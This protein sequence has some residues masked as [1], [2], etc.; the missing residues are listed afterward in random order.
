[1][2]G[3]REMGKGELSEDDLSLL[4][5]LRRSREAHRDQLRRGLLELRDLQRGGQMSSRAG[6]RQPGVQGQEGCRV[7]RG[8]CWRGG[9]G[10]SVYRTLASPSP[11]IFDKLATVAYATESTWRAR[12]RRGQADHTCTCGSRPLLDRGQGPS[13]HSKYRRRSEV[14]PMWGARSCAH[15]EK[16][17]V[18]ELLT[19]ILVNAG[20]LRWRFSLVQ[21]PHDVWHKK[22]RL[23]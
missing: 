19:V 20:P 1:M 12:E 7:E 21:A 6:S 11:L 18:H 5:V 13:T 10:G 3:R 4:V 14:P 9:T 8:F 17:R 15:R 23:G 2:R 22:S 16:S